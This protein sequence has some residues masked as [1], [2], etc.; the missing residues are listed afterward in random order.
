ME[1][2]IALAWHRGRAAKLAVVLR[3]LT[4]SETAHSP[5]P[6]PA[7]AK[8]AVVGDPGWPQ[9]MS[10]HL[11][12][13]RSCR[14]EIC[15]DYNDWVLRRYMYQRAM[16]SGRGQR[17]CPRACPELVE[18]SRAVRDLGSSITVCSQSQCGE[19]T[20]K[21]AAMPW[22][23]ERRKHTRILFPVIDLST[24]VSKDAR[25]GSPALSSH[26]ELSCRSDVWSVMKHTESRDFRI[27]SFEN[28]E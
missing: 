2:A 27:H 9:M 5:M 17:G 19:L 3:V 18:G 1:V 22:D 11:S 16:G 13:Y 20:S 4:K 23:W 7:T 8:K 25:P 14:G 12:S 26:S 28:R 15:D 24:Q 21:D 10:S 6:S